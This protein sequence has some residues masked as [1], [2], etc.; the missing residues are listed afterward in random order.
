MNKNII[1]TLIF[2]V[3]FSTWLNSALAYT[4]FNK[5]LNVYPKSVIAT[6]NTI[7]VP[8]NYTTI[9]EAIDMA[10]EGEIILVKA[11][12]YYEH[13]IVNKPLS[14]VGENKQDTIIDGSGAETVVNIIASNITLSGFT[15]QN[16]G[17]GIYLWG[18]S[19]NFLSGNDVSNNGHGIYL[20]Y[21]G[22]NVVSGNNVS[23]NEHGIYLEGSSNNAL[24][25]NDVSNNNGYGIRLYH[26]GSNVLSGNDAP[27]NGYGIYVSDSDNNIFSGNGLPNNEYGIHLSYSSNNALSGNDAS[28]NSYGIYLWGSSNNFL[29]GNDVSNNGHGIYLS[30]SGD[31]VVSGNNVSENEHGIHLWGANNNIFFQN[32]FINY[33]EPL[34]SI[35]S[36]DS[37]DNGVEG[38]Y[39]SDY[40]GTDTDWDGIN[41]TPYHISENSRDN[42]PLMAR[43]LQFNIVAENQSYRITTVCNSTI[44]NFQFYYDLEAETNAVSFNVN[45]TG[46]KGFCRISIPHALIDPPFEVRIDSLPPSYSK[47]VY[48][49]VTHTW[50][51]F[52][53]GHSQHEVTII[54]APPLEQLLWSQ[55]SIIGLAITVAILFLIGIRYYRLFN[56]QKKVIEAYE[57]E[58]GSF[59]VSHE[60]RARM[61]FIKDVIEREEK[62]ENF[63]K[64][65]GIR[66]QPAN[67]LEDVMEKLGVQKES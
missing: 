22:D 45:S 52:A 16:G 34:R 18:S 54:H 64:K 10:N 48:A 13:I 42:Y 26:S 17:L 33:T 35:A 24:T 1:L 67:T 32:N 63:K 30:Y 44:S 60:E 27:N 28:N 53:Y 50:L 23:E 41:D 19:N 47:K 43:F 58:V 37:W 6:S 9:Q 40:R 31:N 61:R 3:F 51:Y 4:N 25:G 62:I 11:G 12:T 66:I 55:L 49:N 59:P 65:Y 15:I 29:S 57:R 2:L 36:V 46:D 56:K 21:S 38:N 7:W 39:W 14:L 8:D 20:S 5:A